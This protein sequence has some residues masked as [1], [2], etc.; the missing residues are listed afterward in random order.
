MTSEYGLNEDE[1]GD[2]VFYGILTGSAGAAGLLPLSVCPAGQKPT[3]S[4]IGALVSR[5]PCPF[6]NQVLF[7]PIT[8]RRRRRLSRCQ[9]SDT[10]PKIFEAN[11]AKN[12][13]KAG[14]LLHTDTR[15]HDLRDPRNV[16]FYL[17]SSLPHSAGIGPTGP[18][19]CQQPRNPVVANPGLRALLVALDEWVSG[20]KEPPTSRVPLR[21]NGT[22]VASLPQRDEH[23]DRGHHH[24]HQD[25]HHQDGVGFPDIP[26]VTYNGLMTTGLLIWPFSDGVL[27][28]SHRLMAPIS[29]FVP[30]DY[31]TG[32]TSP[33]AGSRGC[34]AAGDVA[35]GAC[36][37]R[38][39][40]ATV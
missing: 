16:R 31:P 27:T 2:R 14:S 24:P 6:A 4:D 33:V 22:L 30:N 21:A 5:A 20:G 26:G 36:A 1:R 28:I 37:L 13:V 9:A 12:W 29:G 35:G 7:D 38:I 17:F 3:A 40:G 39:G 18:G 10:C 8:G 15:G 19:I 23:E 32:T 34:R 11:S 25:R